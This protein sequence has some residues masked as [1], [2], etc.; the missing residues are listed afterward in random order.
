MGIGS[1]DEVMEL[2]L[3]KHYNV[4]N[5]TGICTDYSEILTPSVSQLSFSFGRQ[6]CL[7]FSS[8]TIFERA[9][10]GEDLLKEGR[11]LCT[12]DAPCR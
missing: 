9:Y 10:L 12:S 1:L 3:E 4:R 7:R 5:E 8:G 2:H 11:I 6:V